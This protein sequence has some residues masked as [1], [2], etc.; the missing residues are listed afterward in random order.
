MPWSPRAAD[1]MRALSKPKQRVLVII[2][3]R[4]GSKGI[5]RKNLAP[6][7]GKPL[8]AW[9]IE[10][11]RASRLVDRVVVSTDDP[12]IADTARAWGADVVMR[13][14]R[15]SGDRAPSE[16]ALLHVLDRLRKREAYEPD[17]VV[18]LQ[19]TSP[20]REGGDIDRAIRH[21]R[22][23]R[24]DSL[25]SCTRVE[26]HFVWEK[27]GDTYR[28]VSYD[29]RRRKHRQQITPRY[30]ENGSIYIF[31]PELIR[32]ERNRLGG[33]IV[34]YEMP[35]WKSWQVDAPEDLDLCE[36][37]VRTRLLRRRAIA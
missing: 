32:R 29:Y 11:A 25:F 26:D 3:A 33:R 30:L 19:A 12:A 21:F 8:V 2:P 6:L 4:G 16:A 35:F 7:A 5:P 36:H 24:A 17:L 27:A 1:P 9:S 22:A 31:T 14:A 18:F 23:E 20:A 10:S 15:I 34:A 13:P 37:F 28:S